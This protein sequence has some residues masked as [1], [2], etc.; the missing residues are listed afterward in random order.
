MYYV[1]EYVV[2]R[3]NEAPQNC[4]QRNEVF[5]RVFLRLSRHVLYVRVRLV[6]YRYVRTVPSV[7]ASEER[8]RSIITKAQPGPTLSLALALYIY[9]CIVTF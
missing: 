2:S 3:V 5:S 1:V 7:L 9:V 6:T 8:T 4:M